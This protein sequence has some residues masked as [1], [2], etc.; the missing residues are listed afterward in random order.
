MSLG[1]SSVVAAHSHSM[2]LQSILVLAHLHRPVLTLPRPN[3]NSHTA[4]KSW[5]T[6]SLGHLAFKWRPS[7]GKALAKFSRKKTYKI[8]RNIFQFTDTVTK[9]PGPWYHGK[10]KRYK[11]M[12][13]GLP[14]PSL[15]KHAIEHWSGLYDIYISHIQKLLPNLEPITIF[16]SPFQENYSQTWSWHTPGPSQRKPLSWT[17]CS[18]LINININIHININI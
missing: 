4:K 2:F 18:T 9:C 5:Q 12:C 11:V 7:F 16:F 17:L 3:C 8:N 6:H 14:W 10:N 15:G 1:N 13:L